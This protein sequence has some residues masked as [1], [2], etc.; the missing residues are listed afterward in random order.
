MSEPLETRKSS[1]SSRKHHKDQPSSRT[2]L[3]DDQDGGHHC[4]CRDAM[5]QVNSRL[6]K[7]L[8]TLGTMGAKISDLESKLTG[9]RPGTE[10]EHVK[11]EASWND[12]KVNR[13]NPCCNILGICLL[14]AAL[15]CFFVLATKTNMD[16]CTLVEAGKSFG[17]SGKELMEFVEKRE[18]EAKDRESQNI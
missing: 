9:A 7:I 2:N 1:R 10:N 14:L 15:L 6:D 17:L 5:E 4:S 16:I 18:N 13:S 12:W 8:E 3:S 11:C